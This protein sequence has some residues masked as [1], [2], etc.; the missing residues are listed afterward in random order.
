MNILSLIINDILK[1]I[2]INLERY[3]YFIAYIFILPIILMLCVGSFNILI[4]D[5]FYEFLPYKII[6]ILIIETI[7]YLIVGFILGFLLLPI[8]FCSISISHNG[9]IKYKNFSF[10]KFIFYIFLFPIFFNYI[11]PNFNYLNAFYQFIEI[12]QLCT[13]KI[14]LYIESDYLKLILP[15]IPIAII[16]VFFIKLLIY[17]FFL[18]IYHNFVLLLN[19]FYLIY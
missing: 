19:L 2:V 17:L 3:I 6:N 10:I 12:S 5:Y 7:T 1:Y 14:L 11:F 13:N 8:S 9:N 16:S 4:I 18:D 15:L